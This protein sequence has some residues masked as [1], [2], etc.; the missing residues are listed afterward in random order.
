MWR[1]RS[2][3]ERESSDGLDAARQSW[4]CHAFQGSPLSEGR[5]VKMLRVRNFETHQHYKDR[6]PPWIK[7]HSSVLADYSFGCLQ[8]ASKAHLMLLWVL[9][10]KVSN[11]IPYDLKW[12]TGQL[13]A[14][15]PVDVEEL[16]L[17]GFIEVFTDDSI[18]LA[19]SKQDAPLVEERREEDIKQKNSQRKPRVEG[20]NGKDTWLSPICAV[21]ESK[22]G[23]GSF[24][25]IAGQTAKALSPLTKAGHEPAEIAD[26]LGRYLEQNDAR[27]WNIA[28]FAQT[29]GQWESRE[30]YRDHELTAYAERLS[31]PNGSER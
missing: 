12:I 30:L 26:R 7:L 11:R 1:D 19:P 10:S 4:C 3:Q 13:Q 28:K 23:A 2:A 17:H 6:N 31:R 21:W 9:A 18:L 14:S 20:L 29:F 25:G 24:S 5:R 8:D 22:N 16:I 27:F 15:G